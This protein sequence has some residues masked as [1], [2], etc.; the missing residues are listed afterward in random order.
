MDFHI[1]ENG[2]KN[3]CRDIKTEKKLENGHG[4][5]FF[6]RVDYNMLMLLH[7]RLKTGII[8]QLLL[9]IKFE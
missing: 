2:T 9:A 5:K 1:L 8:L 6:I 3:L 7:P 4:M